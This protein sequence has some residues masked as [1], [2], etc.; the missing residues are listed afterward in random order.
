MTPD[1]AEMAVPKPREL[2]PA[3]LPERSSGAEERSRVEMVLRALRRRSLDAQRSAALRDTWRALWI[4]R[5]LVWVAGAGAVATFGVVVRRGVFNPPHVTSGF[6]WLGDL[7]AA[8]AARWDAAWYLVIA[9][10]GYHP[11][12]G[13]FTASR[14]AFFPLYPLGVGGISELGLQPVLAGVLLSTV[15]L[16]LA[17]YGIHRLCT[18]EAGGLLGVGSASEATARGDQVASRAARGRDVARLAV[19]ATAFAPMAFY[20]SA[21]YSES[22]YLALSVGVFWCARQGRWAWVGALGALAGATRSAGLVLVLPVAILYLYGPREDRPPDY[23]PG[24]RRIG[25]VR[26]R[27]RGEALWL[28]ALPL[29]V[30]AYA[31]YLSLAGGSA[32]EPFHAQ[33]V[34]SRHF[35]GPY[36]GVWDAARAAL[37]GARQLLS[38]QRRHVY[39]GLAGGDP[40]VSAEHNLVLFAFLV[41]ALPAIVGV[42]RRLPAAYGAY[43]LAAL[44]LPLS[45]PV[46]AQPLMSLPRFLVVLFPAVDVVGGLPRAQAAGAS[47]AARGLDAPARLLRGAVRDLALGGLRAGPFLGASHRAAGGSAGRAGDA[48]GA[49]APVACAG[50]ALVGRAW[51]ADRRRRRRAGVSRGDGL[52]PCAPPRRARRRDTRGLAAAVRGSPARRAV[53]G[54]RRAPIGGAA[55]ERDARR[56]ALRGLSGRARRTRGPAQARPVACRGQQLGRLAALGAERYRPRGPA[57]WSVHLGGCRDGRSPP[58]RSSKRHSRTRALRRGEPCTWGTPWSTT[59]WVRTRP[60]SP[61][62]CCAAPALRTRVERRPRPPRPRTRRSGFR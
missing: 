18:L 43:V 49:R 1:T 27:V 60:E 17:L 52:L 28:L 20:F 15:A 30:M 50:A 56:A 8:P 3:A 39:F 24:A 35:A 12:L 13:A 41:A 16:A 57:R 32:L 23:P 21:V 61:P 4:S 58:R 59:C 54:R 48:A 5:L 38:L 53:A 45:Y 6:G 36:L 47:C 42:L 25:R 26:Y 11:E 10:Y 19:L 62:S 22:L 40:F 2:A 9:H 55:D 37:D 51:L 7:L 46:A 44:A 29:G 33:E 34:W 31:A 14:S